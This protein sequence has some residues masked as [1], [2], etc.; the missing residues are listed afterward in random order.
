MD[1]AWV[2]GETFSDELQRNIDESGAPDGSK[3][4]RGQ[5]ED[6]DK[7]NPL[8]YLDYCTTRCLA[9]ETRG[10]HVALVALSDASLRARL[11]EFRIDPSRDL[12]HE[13]YQP[14]F[15]QPGLCY[16][17]FR[18]CSPF[19]NRL[20][21]TLGSCPRLAKLQLS[22]SNGYGGT[23]GREIM[24]DGGVGR[25]MAAMASLQDISL[26]LHGMQTWLAIPEDIVF[27]NLR[28]VRFSCAEVWPK[29][30]VGFIQRH[31]ATLEEIRLVH[32]FAHY[33]SVCPDWS[34][35]EIPESEVG[36]WSDFVQDVTRLIATGST[37]LLP[38]SVVLD[39]VHDVAWEDGC[40][41]V[42][43]TDSSGSDDAYSWVYMGGDEGLAGTR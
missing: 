9:R 8:A 7:D 31:L 11:T 37:R 29:K 2:T 35:E 33:E 10:L 13:E 18:S 19:P 20:I 36:Q 34:G 43:T 22:I 27:S 32:C 1:E 14:E 17:I 24:Q 40:N 21:D 28:R 6:E 38:G 4:N 30:L 15:Y 16:E 25:L 5:E 26:E 12:I 42:G 3:V 41:L 23:Q 39:S